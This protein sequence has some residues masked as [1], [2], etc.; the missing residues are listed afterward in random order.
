VEFKI[1]G[2]TIKERKAPVASCSQPISYNGRDR[3][4]FNGEKVTNKLS[5]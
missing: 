4:F 5:M 2:S 1:S 3:Y